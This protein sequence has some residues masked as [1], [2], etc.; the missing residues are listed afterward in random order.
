MCFG[1]PST[2]RAGREVKQA[3]IKLKNLPRQATDALQADGARAPEIGR[4][5]APLR[6]LLD[7]GGGGAGRRPASRPPEQSMAMAAKLT[8]LVPDLRQDRIG[9][10]LRGT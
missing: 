8:A 6:T 10:N 7:G 4:L 3:P 5:L 9:R 1:V 2:H